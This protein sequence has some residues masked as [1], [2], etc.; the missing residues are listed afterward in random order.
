MTEIKSWKNTSHAIVTEWIKQ[1]ALNRSQIFNFVQHRHSS[2]IFPCETIDSPTEALVG[3]PCA[4]PFR[5]NDCSIPSPVNPLQSQFCDSFQ[6]KKEIKTFNKCTEMYDGR[7]WCAVHVFKNRSLV[8]YGYAY[9]NTTCNGEMPSRE[10]PEYLA[11]SKFDELWQ[12]R[13][14]NLNSYGGGHCFTYNPNEKYLPGRPGNF[15]ARIGKGLD[16]DNFCGYNIHIHSKEV[17]HDHRCIS[18]L[19]LVWLK[20]VNKKSQIFVPP[21]PLNKRDQNCYKKKH[22]FWICFIFR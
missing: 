22:K 14:F 19:I 15:I 8:P 11:S 21:P 7:P 1:N 2:R 6:E 17:M 16:K 13:I 20:I 10:R 12:E 9:C 18:H 3:F 5:V 4:F